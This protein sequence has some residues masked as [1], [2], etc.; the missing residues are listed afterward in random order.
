MRGFAEKASPVAQLAS[1]RVGRSSCS[2]STATQPARARM[3]NV[4]L[5]DVALPQCRV[6]VVSC[7]A[8]ELKT[9]DKASN[10]DEWGE[11]VRLSLSSYRQ[12]CEPAAE[13]RLYCDAQLHRPGEK[14]YDF[15]KIRD[16][17]VADTE[18]KTGKNAGAQT[19]G[20]Q[21]PYR[22]ADSPD[23]PSHRHLA[24]PDRPAHLFAQCAHAHA[25][26]LA[27]PHKGAPC[28]LKSCPAEHV[29]KSMCL[30]DTGAG[31]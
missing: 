2:S 20:S 4:R 8:E 22:D 18:A 19:H 24:A 12:L 31:G 11:F 1:S 9:T 25:R 28:H 23:S 16:E 17:I 14:F 5:S 27:R 7:A 26:R 6:D 3:E 29:A 21:H 13:S 30:C 10:A 15:N